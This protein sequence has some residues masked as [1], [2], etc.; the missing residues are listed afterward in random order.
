[1]ET[2]H[3]YHL[4]K[5]VVYGAFS[6]LVVGLGLGIGGYIVDSVSDIGNPVL[7]RTFPDLIDDYE[8]ESSEIVQLGISVFGTIPAS[9]GFF[10]LAGV[11]GAGYRRREAILYN[12]EEKYYSALQ[13][14]I[15]RQKSLDELMGRD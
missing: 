3:A 7:E 4:T 9:L 1:M 10:V 15:D 6:G 5:G 11:A 2:S 14:E 13:I 8:S 12:N